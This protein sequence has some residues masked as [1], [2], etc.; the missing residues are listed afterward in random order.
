[1]PSQHTGLEVQSMSLVPGRVVTELRELA[2]LTS[3]EQGAQRVA[4]T[5]T[6]RQARDWMRSK[7]EQ[8][9]VDIEQDEAG[10]V[11]ATIHTG[12]RLRRC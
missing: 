4:W 5:Q 2:A 9:P 11:W 1:M 8:L 12:T 10:N 3:N 6:W 7:L